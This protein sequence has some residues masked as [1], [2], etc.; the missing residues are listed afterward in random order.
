MLRSLVGSEMCI[1]DSKGTPQPP[2]Y[3][4]TTKGCSN[5]NA[6]PSPVVY[7]I[8]QGKK[9]PV[10]ERDRRIQEEMERKQRLRDAAAEYLSTEKPNR[11]GLERLANAPVLAQPRAEAPL[12]PTFLPL[13]QQRPLGLSPLQQRPRPSSCN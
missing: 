12:R 4:T 3:P 2:P 8:F 11:R 5:E 7:C 13:P 1:R 9:I 10:R 6:A